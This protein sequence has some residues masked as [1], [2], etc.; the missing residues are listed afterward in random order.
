MNA[1]LYNPHRSAQ[2]RTVF[3]LTLPRDPFLSLSPP[4]IKTDNGPWLGHGQ[5]RPHLS[6]WVS[7]YE[8]ELLIMRV[9]YRCMRSEDRRTHIHTHTQHYKELDEDI[10]ESCAT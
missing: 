9:K 3:Y 5:H 4:S 2:A 8:A 6:Q 1:G 7:I 10:W